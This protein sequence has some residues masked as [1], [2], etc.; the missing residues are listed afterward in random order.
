MPGK[1]SMSDMTAGSLAGEVHSALVPAEGREE[2]LQAPDRTD[3]R[4][5]EKSIVPPVKLSILIP[6]YN[7]A[8]YIEQVI[9]AVRNVQ[10]PEGIS[11]EI[12][13]VD[14][15]S[16]DGTSKI[17]EGM[18]GSIK[19]HHSVLN[20]GKGT[21]I[22][23]ALTFATG[24]IILIQDADLEYNP[25]DYWS[26][27]RPIVAGEAD[28]VYGSRF[29]GKIE[30]MQFANWLANRILTWTVRLLYG[31]KITDEATGHKVFRA[32]VLKQ[33]KLTCRR[34]EFCPEVTAKLCKKG[35]QIVEV[36]INYRARMTNEGKKIRWTDG[37]AALLTLLR[38]RF[39]D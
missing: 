18:N 38:Y 17:L 4:V 28:V 31:Q 10:L 25:D 1:N 15:G 7:E 27:I 13:C 22:R 36:P 33:V 16:L 32:D 24:D 5:E 26:L 20:F 2:I 8:P 19:V 37:V 11:T 23:I 39:F 21:A 6:V 14:D 3:V 30:N 34:F 9:R 12:V 35:Y 29:L